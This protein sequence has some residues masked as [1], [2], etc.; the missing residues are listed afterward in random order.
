MTVHL[1]PDPWDDPDEGDPDF[2]VPQGS[3]LGQ[4]GC[5]G[6]RREGKDDE[7]LICDQCEG[8]HH[9]PDAEV[10]QERAKIHENLL[11]QRVADLEQKRGWA[12]QEVRR[13]RRALDAERGA[14]ADRG[15]LA[16][17]L[18]VAAAKNRSCN[19]ASCEL[20]DADQV[21]AWAAEHARRPPVKVNRP[22][23]LAFRTSTERP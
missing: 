1:G 4:C 21:K 9:R 7:P 11:R 2:H 3:T 17:D 6:L 20:A 12:V 19:C 22:S 16:S 5:C 18:A 10:G 14:R 13:L 8:H 15:H 23:S